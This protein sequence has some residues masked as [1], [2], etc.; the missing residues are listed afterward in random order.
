MS[1][2]KPKMIVT[3]GE[4]CSSDCILTDGMM[5]PSE[6]CTVFLFILM[7]DQICFVWPHSGQVTMSEVRVDVASYRWMNWKGIQRHL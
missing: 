3:P 4:E 5:E 6:S 2:S 1:L 7:F